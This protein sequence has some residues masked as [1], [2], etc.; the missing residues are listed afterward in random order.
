MSSPGGEDEQDES[1]DRRREQQSDSAGESD[2]STD[3]Q[4]VAATEPGFDIG[5]PS[6]GP[7][8]RTEPEEDSGLFSDEFVVFVRDLTTSVLAVMLLGVYIFMISGVWPPMVAIES[9][10]MEPNMEVNDIVFVMDSDR[11]QPAE[12]AA[13]SGVV[14]AETGAETGYSN[15]GGYGD[16]IVFAPDGNEDRTPV[17]HRAMFWVEEGENWFERADEEF[18]NG[19]DSCEEIGACEA[20]HDGFI[21]K[22]D[23]NSAYDQAGNGNMEPVKPEWVVGTA[24]VRVPRLGWLRLRFQ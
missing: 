24:E 19:A 1:G 10:S 14:T 20:P 18:V 9:G 23:A 11:F 5:E 7:N 3:Q 4:S 17:I 6:E 12:A 21:T 16:V 8:Y 2:R 15:Y 22:G 13:E